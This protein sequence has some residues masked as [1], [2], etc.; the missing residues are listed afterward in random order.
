VSA[1]IDTNAWIAFF[2]DSPVLREEAAE[3]MESGQLCYVSIA[4]IWEAAI[5]VALGKLKL[6]YD[7][8]SDLPR[9]L[10]EN[11]FQLLSVEIDDATSVCDLPHHHGDSFDRIMAVQAMRRNLRVISRDAVFEKYG[12][13]RVW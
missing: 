11:G 2:E 13:R 3:F 10:D 7:L 1:L 8:R 5:K 6:P 4:S 12:L 9:L